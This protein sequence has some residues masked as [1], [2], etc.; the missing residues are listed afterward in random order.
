MLKIFA[1]KNFA[2]L[3]NQRHFIFQLNLRIDLS[4]NHLCEVGNLIQNV[5]N[6]DIIMELSGNNIRYLLGT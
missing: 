4:N 3:R 1:G 2:S 5:Q 6:E